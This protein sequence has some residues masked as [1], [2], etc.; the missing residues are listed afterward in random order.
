[1]LPNDKYLADA[2]VEIAK[3]VGELLRHYF[4]H[5][6]LT[7]GFKADDSV[8]TEADL[9]A[10]QFLIEH[11][12]QLEPET[13]ILSEELNTVYNPDQGSGKSAWI[14]DPLDGSTNFS[15][16][17]V[18]WGCLLTRLINDE[19]VLSILYFPMLNE[20]Y[21]AQSG[22][23]ASLNGVPLTINPPDTK[24]KRSF[25]CCC[26]R[27]FRNYEISVP[28]K[29]RIFGSTGYSLSSVARG[30]AMAAFDATPKIWDIAGGWLLVNEAG[31]VVKIIDGLSPFPLEQGCNYAHRNLPMLA[32]PSPDVWEKTRRRIQPHSKSASGM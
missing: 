22:S 18:Y 1:M 16:G 26:S 17:V 27:T 13:F 8:I 12:K 25:F 14:I 7:P 20:L 28:Y 11:L 15:L 19:P 4:Q 23:G 24:D 2:A 29:T 31:G 6:E 5:V 32:A 10:N 21:L 30:I 9:A 3:S